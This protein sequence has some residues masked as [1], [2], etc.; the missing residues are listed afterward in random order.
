MAVVINDFEV[1]PAPTQ[2]Q[3]GGAKQDGAPQGKPESAK[4]I[5]KTMQVQHERRLR[6]AV[7]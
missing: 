2:E 6:L 4:K 7:Y 5:Q 3:S 1:A